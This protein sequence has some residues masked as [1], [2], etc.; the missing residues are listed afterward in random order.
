MA[1]LRRL[2]GSHM[3]EKEAIA[4]VLQH[5]IDGDVRAF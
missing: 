5:Y 3:T 1:A 2:W 4:R